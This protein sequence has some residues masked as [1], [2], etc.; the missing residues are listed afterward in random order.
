MCKIMEK[1]EKEAAKEAAKEAEI[2]AI[3][4]M[5]NVLGTSKDD[6]LRIY[7]KELYDEAVRDLNHKNN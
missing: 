7:P 4:S 1:Y 5:I 3:K 2:K 6:I